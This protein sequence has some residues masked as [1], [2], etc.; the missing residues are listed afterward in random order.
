M[1]T[2]S[3]R[4][5]DGRYAYSGDSRGIKAVSTP[6]GAPLCFCPKAFFPLCATWP[7]RDG[8]EQEEPGQGFSFG[9]GAT[10]VGLEA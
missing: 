5:Y 9:R 2:R 7:V 1:L 4:Y 3:S 6:I 10:A 8:S